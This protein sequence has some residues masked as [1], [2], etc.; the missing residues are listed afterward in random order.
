MGKTPSWKFLVSADNKI[1]V[2]EKIDIEIV[3]HG[4]TLVSVN[5][6]IKKVRWIK[7]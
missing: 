7:N 5:E 6:V 3:Y 1:L 2:G 4:N